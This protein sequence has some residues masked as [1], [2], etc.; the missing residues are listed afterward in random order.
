MNRLPLFL[1]A[2]LA[3][4]VV[5]PGVL[6]AEDDQ[7]FRAAFAQ[8]QK[9]AHAL[10]DSGPAYLAEL[11]KG[12]RRLQ[13]EFPNQGELYAELLYVADHR[14]N[15]SATKLAREIL[16]WPA[17]DGVKA[18]ARGVLAKKAALGKLYPLRLPSI[19]GAAIDLAKLRGKVVLLDFWATWCPPCREGLPELKRT[20]EKFQ[21]RGFE[22]VGLSFD[23]EVGKLRKFVAS[24]KIPWPQHGLGE[25]M[26]GK[27][28]Q[29][30]GITS[31]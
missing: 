30:F 10:G 5:L 14:E 16:A 6:R 1:S 13:T 11:E 20:Y 28:A 7:R 22:I 12:F 18:K 8:V 3:V 31:L 9:A 26:D 24:E 29:R 21:A 2:W 25:N 19:D 23:S 4:L 17:P 27:L 15:E